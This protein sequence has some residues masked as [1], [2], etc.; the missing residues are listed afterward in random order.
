VGKKTKERYKIKLMKE[1]RDGY[2]FLSGDFGD[3]DDTKTWGWSK[4]ENALIF[5]RKK[6]EG[7]QK[8]LAFETKLIP[9]YNK[10]I[11]RTKTEGNF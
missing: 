11:H 5:D 4:E 10:T 8:I 9:A 1:E 2:N 3:E 6:A 7:I